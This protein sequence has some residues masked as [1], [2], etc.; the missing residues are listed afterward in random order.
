MTNTGKKIGVAVVGCGYWGPHLMRNFSDQPGSDLRWLVDQDPQRLKRCADALSQARTTTDLSDA[1]ADS[2][3]H[4]VALA[5]PVSTHYPL[6]KR[7]LLAGRHVLIEKPMAQKVSECEELIALA[8][9]KGLD[10]DGGSHLHF[11]RGCAE[12]SRADRRRRIRADLLLRFGARKSG[13]VPARCERHLG[14]GAA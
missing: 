8:N 13:I 5:T 3:L 10:A 7:C 9:A 6:A 11:H 14:S 2:K 4:A 1:L 12:N